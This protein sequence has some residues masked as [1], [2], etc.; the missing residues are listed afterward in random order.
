MSC[1]LHLFGAIPNPVQALRAAPEFFKALKPQIDGHPQSGTAKRCVPFLDALSQGFIIPLWADLF[2]RA[3]AGNITLDF[4][5]NFQQLSTVEEHSNDQITGHPLQGSPYGR[6]PLKFISPWLV[7]TEPGIS[8]LFTSPLNHMETRFKLADGLVDTDTYANNV[9]LPFFWTGG[10]G[11][12]FIPQGTPLV[13]VIPFRREAV[14][15]DVRAM[16]E[17]DRDKKAEVAAKLGAK[18]RNGYRDLFWHKRSGGKDQPVPDTGLAWESVTL[19]G[20][21]PS[22]Y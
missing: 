14:A 9:N 10:D 3:N 20:Q 17:L 13:Q 19:G 15:L 2:V 21:T 22:T 5:R 4:P 7:R 16:D 1:E 18:M 8:C 6:L 12:F 11:E